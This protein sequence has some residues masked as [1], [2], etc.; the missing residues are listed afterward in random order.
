V[1]TSEPYQKRIL[2]GIILGSDGQKMSKSKGNAINPDEMVE[3]FGADTL[4]AY[5]MFIG[6][7]DQ[8]SAWNNA[9]IM[10]VHRFLKRV[11]ANFTK[12]KNA[13]DTD[14]LLVKLNQTI[15]NVTEDLENFQMNTVIS[16]LMELNNTIEKET[17]VS[18]DSFKIFLQLLYP[19]CPHIASE[20]WKMIDDKTNIENATWPKVNEKYLIANEIEIAVSING[21]TRQIIKVK[22][23][24][25]QN[26]IEE[27]A[28]NNVKIAELIKS[29]NVQKI[30]YITGRILNFV[31]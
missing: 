17:L 27:I 20:L 9:G 10:G 30:I 25:T 18:P 4:R 2:H 14:V 31:I 23:D 5:I 15:Q 6:P 21:K 24:A 26:E 22:S 29:K 13:Q 11:W 7:Y 28:K 1:P 8:E 19:A 12:I 3:K 16:K